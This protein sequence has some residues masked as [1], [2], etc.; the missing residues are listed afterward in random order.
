MNYREEVT[1]TSSAVHS[2]LFEDRLSH[3]ALGLSG[4]AGE[5]TDYI[6]KVIHHGKPFE[7]SKLVDELGD[8]RWYLEHLAIT[9]G[10]SMQEI[11][12]ANV[13]K[14]RRRYPNGFSKEAS[15]NRGNK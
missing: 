15:E 12:E 2:V 8:V 1:R 14:L 5:V 3:G 6:K 10:V 4:E 11:E 9:V 13:Y 7:R